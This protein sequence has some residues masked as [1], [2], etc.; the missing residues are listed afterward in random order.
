MTNCRRNSGT[1]DQVLKAADS[2]MPRTK[3]Q[4]SELLF[5]QQLLPLGAGRAAAN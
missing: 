2:Q 4:L 3:I 1:D 5:R